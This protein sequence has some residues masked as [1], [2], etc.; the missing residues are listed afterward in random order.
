M[1]NSFKSF[2]NNSN[3]LQKSLLIMVSLL[4]F[5]LVFSIFVSDLLAAL[6]SLSTIIIIIKEKKVFSFFDNLKW[7]TI[8]MILFYTIIII[9]LLNSHDLKS[10]FLP[11]F[12]YFRF[13]LMSF[14]IFYIIQHHKFSLHAI[15]CS[16]LFVFI[17]LVFDSLLQYNFGQNIFGYKLQSY[18]TEPN[19][20]RFITSFFGLEKKL[21]SYLIRIIPFIISLIIYLNLAVFKKYQIKEIIILST[22]IMIL[23]S[24]ERTALIMFSIF[25]LFYIKILKHKFKILGI[26]MIIFFMV[27]NFNNSIF[28]KLINGTLAQLE[29]IENHRDYKD[30]D[31]K[32]SNIKYYSN[33]HQN[34]ALTALNIFKE[35]PLTGAGIKTFSHICNKVDYR[36]SVCSTHPHSTYPQILS[37]IG[38]FGFLIIVSIFFIIL[39]LNLKMKFSLTDDD[40]LKKSFYVLNI[41][42]IIN[43]MPFIPSGSFFNNWISLIGFL[44]LGFW[45]YL[46]LETK[47]R[48]ILFS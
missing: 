18:C 12:F 46:F 28:H 21:G 6:I 2:S 34:L 33:E 45:I 16:L 13:F 31:L 19:C 10:S 8:L 11:S 40:N 39:G 4:P 43:I 42:I 26:L 30:Q 29:I 20:Q 7:V 48:N 47:K 15:L 24:S 22:L 44:P 27:L 9:S 36:S 5:A 17:M 1:L 41:G 3:F 37:E 32:F 25:F 35:N 38:V 23:F 14:G